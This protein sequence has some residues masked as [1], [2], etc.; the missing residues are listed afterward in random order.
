MPEVY[1]PVLKTTISVSEEGTFELPSKE[2][3]T[4]ELKRIAREINRAARQ[5]QLNIEEE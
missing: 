3:T 5:F 4:A 1:V 2:Y